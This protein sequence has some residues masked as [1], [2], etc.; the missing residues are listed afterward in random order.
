[1]KIEQRPKMR[2]VMGAYSA[3]RGKTAQ[4]EEPH[5][6]DSSSKTQSVAVILFG[7]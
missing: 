1:M 6:Q 5:N 4:E 2:I 7:R 3:D